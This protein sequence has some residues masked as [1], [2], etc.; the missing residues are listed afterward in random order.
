MPASPSS[1]RGYVAA[2]AGYLIAIKPPG[3]LDLKSLLD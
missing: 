2:K 3:L 1:R